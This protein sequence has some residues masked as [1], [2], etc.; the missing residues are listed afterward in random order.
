MIMS[1]SINMM[2]MMMED[3]RDGDHHDA[4]YDDHGEA[5]MMMIMTRVRGRRM[6]M[7]V[8]IMVNSLHLNKCCEQ[9]SWMRWVGLVLKLSYKWHPQP[10]LMHFGYYCKQII[11]NRVN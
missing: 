4:H 8:M 3:N 10:A 11:V 7:I 9:T 2:M 6:L 1:M 5:I